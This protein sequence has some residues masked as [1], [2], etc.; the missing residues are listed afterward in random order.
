MQD[1]NSA[2]E[3]I[4]REEAGTFPSGSMEPP[5]L[6][7]GQVSPTSGVNDSTVFTYTVTYTDAENYT[8]S[9]VNVII[10][11]TPYSMIKQVPSDNN[12]MDGCVFNYS[13]TL[14]AGTHEYAFNCSDGINPVSIGPFSGPTVNLLQNY[15]M[16]PGSHYDWIEISETGTR[17]TLAGYDDFTQIIMMPFSFNCYDR[18]SNILYINT[19]GYVNPPNGLG[20]AD[21]FNFPSSMSVSTIAPFFDDLIAASPCNIYYQSFTSPNR[22]VVEWKDYQF[23]GGSIAGSFQLVLYETGEIIFNYDYL[24][25]AGTHTCGL[26][27]GFN[28][29]YYNQYVGLGAGTDDF[30]ILFTQNR[31]DNAPTLSNDTINPA[32]GD[33]LTNFNFTVEY[34]DLDNDAPV[35]MDLYVNGTRHTMSKVDVG[36]VNFTDGCLYQ[37][38][39]MLPSGV[40]EFYFAASDFKH[41]V[42]TTN[43]TVTVNYTNNN[44]PSLVS[45]TVSPP[46]GVNDTTSFNFLVTYTDL[47]NNPAT[48]VIAIVNGVPYAMVKQNPTDQNYLDG[49][50]YVYST[51]MPAGV[52]QYSFNCTDGIYN[53]TIGPF[54][55]PTVGVIQ[56]YFMYPGVPYNWIECYGYTNLG[57]HGVTGATTSRTLPFTFPFYGLNFTSIWICVEGFASFQ[58]YPSGANVNFPTS[59]YNYM[60]CPFWDDLRAANPCNIWMRSLSNPNR[61][62]IEYR[63]IQFQNSTVCGSFEIILFEDGDII[64]NYDYLTGTG[65]PTTG[66]NFGPSASYF[67]QYFGLNGTTDDFSILFTQKRNENAPLL[68]DGAIA[69]GSGNQLTMYNFSINVTDADNATPAFVSTVIN[70]TQYPML[71]V[72]ALDNDYADGCLYQLS[73]MLPSGTYEYYFRC[74][75][76]RFETNSSIQPLVVGVLNTNGPL[77]SSGGVT[78][79]SGQNGTTMFTYTVTYTDVDNNP[80]QGIDVIIDGV[81]YAMIKQTPSDL[82]YTDGCVYFY[83]TM[84]PATTHEYTFNCTDGTF[85]HEI[86]PFSGPYVGLLQNYYLYPGIPYE[87]IDAT[88][89]TRLTSLNGDNDGVAGAGTPF[90]ISFYGNNHTAVW[91]CSNGFLRLGGATTTGVNVNFP[92]ASYAN[93]IAPFWDDLQCTNPSNVYIRSLTSPNRFVVE[94]NNIQYA[95]LTTCGSFQV[96]FF[97]TGDIMFNYDYLTGAGTP[98]IGLNYGTN[99]SY[100][101]QYTGFNGTV[102]DFSIL[103]TQKQ[104]AYA[105]NLTIDNVNPP[106]GNQLTMF[107]FS[108]TYTDLDNAPPEYMNLHINSTNFPMTKVNALDDDYT[109]GCVY[110]FLTTL[111]SDSYSYYFECFDKRFVIST[112]PQSLVV[113]VLNNNVPILLNGSVN[114]SSGVNDSTIFTFSV[115][116]TDADNNPPQS[117][118]VIIDGV[119]Y[120]MEKEII[121]D[122]DYTDGCTYVFN[123]TFDDGMH[124]YSFNCSD[125]TFTNATILYQG[126]LVRLLD[127]YYMYSDA[128]YEWIDTS[129]GVRCNLAGVDDN[130]ELFHLPFV[131]N[132]YGFNYTSFYVCTNGFISFTNQT[133]PS[134][135]NFP[136]TSI[137]NIIAPFWDDL[138]AGSPCNIFVKNL[139]SPNRVVVSWNDIRFW[140]TNILCGTFEVVLFETGDIMFLYD[141]ISNAG[142]HTCGLNYGSDTRFYNQYTGLSSS[143]DNFALLFSK[144]PNVNGPSLDLDGVDPSTGHQFTLFNF[145]VNYTDIDNNA[146]ST[147]NVI[148]NSTSYTMTQVD[149]S[150]HNFTDG[151][152]FS[153]TTTLPSASYDYYFETADGRNTYSTLVKQLNVSVLNVNTPALSDPQVDPSAGLGLVT[154]F[155]YTVNYTDADDNA[156]QFVQVIINGTPYAMTKQVPSDVNFLDGCIFTFSTALPSGPHQY[157]FNCSDGLFGTEIGPFAGPT[158]E[159]PANYTMIT[160]IAF[161]WDD[162]TNGTRCNLA[163][164]DDSAELF[165]FPFTF[166]FYGMNFTSFYVCTNGFISFTY[167]VSPGNEDFPT[168]NH[169]YMI[170]P[171]WADLVTTGPCNIFVRNLTSPNRVAIAWIDIEYLSGPTVGSFEAV[172]HESGEIYFNYLNISSILTYTTGLNYG[173][174]DRFY[175]QYSNLTETTANFSIYF[176]A[177][178]NNVAPLLENGSVDPPA[179]NQLATY[180]FS[181]NY[182]DADNNLPVWISIFINS[183]AYPMSKVDAGDYNYTDGCCF[184]F[185]TSTLQPGLVE[186][187][188]G[189]Y[190]GKFYS[191]STNSSMTITEVNSFSPNLTTGS[192]S[193]TSGNN[194]TTVY[195]FSVV[196]ADQDNNAPSWINVTINGTTYAMVKA[197]PSDENYIDGCI[198]LYSTAIQLPGTYMYQFDVM[199]S[200]YGA[201]LGPF[202]DLVVNE[203]HFIF[204]DGMIYNWTGYFSWVGMS[205]DAS[206]YFNLTEN[207]MFNIISNTSW[208]RDVNGTDGSIQND[209]GGPFING[210]HEWTKILPTIGLGSVLPLSIFM[211]GDQ[212]FTVTGETMIFALGQAFSCWVLESPEGSIACYDKYTGLLIV[213]TFQI[214]SL[215]VYYTIDILGTNVPFAPNDNGPELT[216]GSVSPISGTQTTL[217]NFTVIYSDQDDN[218]PLHVDVVIDGVAYSMEP[219]DPLDANFTDGRVYQFVVPLQ[220]GSHVFWFNCSDGKF[221][222]N[223]I[224]YSGL[225]VSPVNDNA[226]VLLDGR[227]VPSRGFNSTT[228]YSFRTIYSDA[229]NN[230]PM[231]VR[232]TVN[233]SQYIM[234]KKDPSDINYMD[235]CTY[236]YNLTIATPGIYQYFFNCTDGVYW[237]SVGPFT[238]PVVNVPPYFDGMCADYSFHSNVFG[239]DVWHLNYSLLSM[240]T[241]TTNF[242]TDAGSQ[243]NGTWVVDFNTRRIMSSSTWPSI[244]SHDTFWI[245][246]NVSIGMKVQIG[247][248]SGVDGVFT[249][250]GSTIIN[251]STHG[252]LDVWILDQDGSTGVVWYEKST[253]LLVNGTFDISGLIEYELSLLGTNVTFEVVT[254]YLSEGKVAPVIGSL[255]I[256]YNFTVIY[257]SATNTAPDDVYLYLDGF[258]YLMV[259]VD[260]LD[261]NYVDGALF[262]HMNATMIVGEH[263]FYF[264]TRVGSNY[265]VYPD[266]GGI[267]APIVIPYEFTQLDG[268]DVTPDEGDERTAYRFSIVFQDTMNSSPISINVVLDGISYSMI[269]NPL[270]D[271]FTNGVEYYYINDTMDLGNHVYHFEATNATTSLRYPEAGELAGPVVTQRYFMSVFTTLP[272]VI[273]GTFTSSEWSSAFVYRTVLGLEFYMNPGTVVRYVPVTVYVINDLTNVYFCVILENETFNGDSNGDVLLVV[274]DDDLNGIL[275]DG[276]QAWFIGTSPSTSYY[277]TH[278]FHYSDVSGDYIADISASGSE[279]GSAAFSHSNNASSGLFGNYTFEFTMPYASA[280]VHDLQILLEDDCG[281]KFVFL[282]AVDMYMDNFPKQNM[283][284]EYTDPTTYGI[285]ELDPNVYRPESTHPTDML[286]LQNATGINITWQ[287]TSENG[288]GSYRILLNGSVLL[289]WQV[290][291]GN[292]TDI[293]VPVDTGAGIGIWNYTIQFNDSLGFIGIPDTVLVTVNDPPVISDMQVLSTTVIK[294]Q[295]GLFINWT[296][297]DDFPSRGLYRVLLDGV[298]YIGW[299]AWISG[300]PINVPID[301]NQGLG[302]FNYS[303]LYH[304]DLGVFGIQ[305]TVV[306]T[307][308]MNPP[309]AFSLSS[310]AGTPDIDGNFQLTWSTALDAINYSLYNHTGP[311]TVI[312]GTVQLMA[313]GLTVT[314]VSISGLGNGTWYYIIIAF[315]D[316]GNSSSNY[317]AVSIEHLRPGAF[318]LSANNTEPDFD[319]SFTLSWDAAEH[320][321]NYSVYW[322]NS[323][324]T[325]FDGNVYLVVEDL[326]DTSYTILDLPNGTYYYIVVAFNVNGNQT[327]NCIAINVSRVVP[328]PLLLE[329]PGGSP[330]LDGIIILIWNESVGADNYTVYSFTHPI[331]IINDSLTIEASEITQ[332]MFSTR[333]VTNGTYYFIIAANNSNGHTLSNP[334]SVVV[335]LFWP[336]PF[337]LS[338][339]AGSPDDDGAFT[340]TWSPSVNATNYTVY[341]HTSPITT[342]NISVVILATGATNTSISLEDMPDGR[343]YFLVISFNDLGNTSSNIISVVVDTSS[344][345]PSIIDQIIQFLT[346]NWFIVL[347]VVGG[348]VVTFA[349]IARRKKVKAASKKKIIPDSKGLSTIGTTGAKGDVQVIQQKKLPDYQMPLESPS[350][351]RPDSQ[352]NEALES[353]ARE[354]SAAKFYCTSCG[355]YH[356]IQAPNMETWYSCPKCTQM[357]V[358]V[359]DCPSCGNAMALTKE[360]YESMKSTG[361]FCSRCHKV[362]KI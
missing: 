126:P 342:I 265:L 349:A 282:D 209:Y 269:K 92:T 211:T 317:I 237:A 268:G 148:I 154:T 68:S 27:Y 273:D 157:L 278:D 318:N 121:T 12:Y 35:S 138:R 50:V 124:E 248:L 83:S 247:L 95:N 120:A 348:V 69:P 347:A 20:T 109:D 178:E 190:D 97:E 71:K 62:V 156:P 26:N 221:P 225:S 192:V 200:A 208:N 356:V 194:G 357:L 112:I 103:F 165:H 204:F 222:N 311:I 105:P 343:Y 333:M 115:N 145:S 198:Y 336:A 352:G 241:F 196:Y 228:I 143:T 220:A 313:S 163:Y 29:A 236:E 351:I 345:S 312:N 217:F 141:Y 169:E 142:T 254:T 180:N 253:G 296:I 32:T 306:I 238:G 201:S 7:I 19:N 139:T 264:S 104:N 188:F 245:F 284:F 283:A 203:V 358:N 219:V 24:N 193:P 266:S 137:Q 256:Q 270:D 48:E 111:A 152:I 133:S 75:D 11:G 36:D 280:D 28:T 8:P 55:G 14:G 337:T 297:L 21:N 181:V 301:T 230:A 210:S 267:Q 304:D 235:G 119:S 288:I 77:L 295:T 307:V 37:C 40:N 242:T 170:A 168:I 244:F 134:N 240:M 17:S 123:T 146:P 43:Q 319:G 186:Y 22:F 30:S 290:W 171:F 128:V 339:N 353:Q 187:Y 34:T 65:S 216:N 224:T 341:M 51:T 96:V 305:D 346:E 175:N 47:D 315:N 59:S 255:S 182:T 263:L 127:N 9:E 275:D 63:D 326:S 252:L 350:T 81:P 87:W 3:N 99:T 355:N 78:P 144:H 260:P 294:N 49:C 155:T 303:L 44:S 329:V 195:T 149:P 94:W 250:T 31:N 246:T 274:F 214:P 174:D 289:D 197:N 6:T 323:T 232:V 158:V 82:N 166:T 262:H 334:V 223:T 135:V 42:N 259:P 325:I 125:G 100:Y 101:N 299:N 361:M 16:Y 76:N 234:V 292:G 300:T 271:D 226:P 118:I 176:T 46:T 302:N 110:E 202:L 213:A 184:Q 23:D 359:I 136:S 132:F 257:T 167:E 340:I 287:L 321:D 33:Q 354:P 276:E 151:C 239:D 1:A 5:T 277:S 58:G 13:T 131:F 173:I 331:T 249:V 4:S 18:S 80:P 251:S 344:T 183:S 322:S 25:A 206:E 227:V 86:G 64:F 147:I 150:D 45:P 185:S 61:Y 328:G 293:D 39:T 332:L 362:V 218:P 84:L 153:Y 56:N 229:D 38:N 122:I 113:D 162:A 308:V 324:I 159:D 93:M 67:N 129:T 310:D 261:T 212:Q 70:G 41:F 330:D 231:E 66:L 243:S 360:D 10:D 199:D 233:G 160:G 73:T 140:G 15:Y 279:D 258:P 53:S 215:S 79:T 207:A 291:T 74:F 98:T 335:I 314:N 57:M 114:P 90:P 320:A 116:Y 130:T 106:A 117:V 327:S 91:V 177:L 85:S 285:L 191:F 309:G 164:Q 108:V 107:N 161:S 54:T 89:G 88:L 72:D 102:D 205:A 2:N 60:I 179:G 272:P 298:E 316:F 286:V 189:C 338:S 52:H 281:I 172:L